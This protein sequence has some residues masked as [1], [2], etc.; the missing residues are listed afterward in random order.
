MGASL[1]IC[2]RCRV[3]VGLNAITVGVLEER[4]VIFWPIVGSRAWFPMVTAAAS[5]PG[6]VEAID[7][8]FRWRRKANVQSGVGIRRY[9]LC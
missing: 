6:S 1:A 8:V 3:A 9:R 2:L 4:R 7:T 5:N